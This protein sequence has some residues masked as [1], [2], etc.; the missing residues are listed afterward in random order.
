MPSIDRGAKLSALS[1]RNKLILERR[2]ID[3]FRADA[4][5]FASEGEKA[6]LGNDVVAL[7]VLRHYRT[8]ARLLDWSMSPFVGA[9]FA[10]SG[11]DTEDG[12]LWAFD[13][14]CY[15]VEGRK[16]WRKWRE[17]TV[18]RDGIHFRAEL[19]AFLIKEPP[20]WL[21][22]GFYPAGFP[23]QNVQHG[24]YTM[25]ARFNRDHASSIR[26]VLKKSGRYHLYVVRRNIKRALREALR[27]QH[28]IWRGSLY[29]DSAGAAETA[30]SMFLN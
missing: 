24:A 30:H 13:E 18:N 17:T 27:K 21:I 8:A 28:G 6:A 7:M 4:R 23:R 5:Y 15:E 22:V 29:P 1:R 10:V 14:H 19:T 16:Q 3:I 12:E 25:T 9:Y 11:N 2:S 26:R 20:D